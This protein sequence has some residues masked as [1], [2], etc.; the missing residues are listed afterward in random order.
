MCSDVQKHSWNELKQ[1]RQIERWFNLWEFNLNRFIVGVHPKI[2]KIAHWICSSHQRIIIRVELQFKWHTGISFRFRSFVHR[3]EQYAHLIVLHHFVHENSQ[4]SKNVYL[5][6][7]R[8]PSQW[9]GAHTSVNAQWFM[10]IAAES[11]L[12]IFYCIFVTWKVDWY[13]LV[14]FDLVACRIKLYVNICICQ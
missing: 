11:E 8:Q 12:S 7:Y 2:T 4:N 10:H 5:V 9:N 3:N 14:W 6:A 1:L 13:G